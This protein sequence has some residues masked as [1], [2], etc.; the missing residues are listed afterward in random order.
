MY[1]ENEMRVLCPH[2]AC[3]C[4]YLVKSWTSFVSFGSKEIPYKEKRAFCERCGGEVQVGEIAE[5]NERAKELAVQY[6]IDPK[7]INTKFQGKL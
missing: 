1:H 2:C 7:S 4:R 6:V 3:E 5:E